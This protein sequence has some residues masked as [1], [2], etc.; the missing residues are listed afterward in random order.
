MIFSCTAD[1]CFSKNAKSKNKI[2][3]SLI[4]I[5]INLNT[6][7]FN[8]ISI[9]SPICY[10]FQRASSAKKIYTLKNP[11]LPKVSTYNLGRN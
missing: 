6:S 1:Y 3:L 10:Y 11:Y 5:L 8:F 2:L 9:E 7:Q 4:N